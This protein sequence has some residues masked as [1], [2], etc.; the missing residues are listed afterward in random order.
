M[1]EILDEVEG[2]PHYRAGNKK[3]DLA[4]MEDEDL[5]LSIKDCSKKTGESKYLY[6]LIGLSL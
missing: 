5:V 4:W 6:K 3:G 2:Y 1:G